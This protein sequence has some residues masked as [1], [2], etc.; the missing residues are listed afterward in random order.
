MRVHRCG[1]QRA[2]ADQIPDGTRQI[3]LRVGHAD[4]AHGS[5]DVEED[6]G[7]R[8]GV[9]KPLEK[10]RFDGLVERALDRAARESP[11]VHERRPLDVGG[12][13]VVPRE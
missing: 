6:A 3:R 10:L 7:D 5:V 2:R 11:R 4:D 12:Q 1:N 13:T 9:A 8:H